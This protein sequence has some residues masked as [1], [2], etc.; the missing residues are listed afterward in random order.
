[1]IDT[2]AGWL[3]F[4][5]ALHLIRR[6]GIYEA[7]V[8]RRLLGVRETLV[9]HPEEALDLETM[10][11]AACFSKFHFLRLFREAYGE[12]PGRYLARVRLERARLLLET[13]DRRVTEICFDVGYESLSSF[14][15]AFRARF[16]VPPERYRRHWVA[17]PRPIVPASRVPR[18]FAAMYG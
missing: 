6:E 7:S 1:M 8:R 2:T 12:T 17:V 14:S 16:G 9:R 4:Y 10:A 3:R 15:L 5:G 18:C 11:R 13:T